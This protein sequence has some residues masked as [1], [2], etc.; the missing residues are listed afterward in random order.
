MQKNE[1]NGKKTR[2]ASKKGK[3]KTVE[4]AFG[5]AFDGNG[6]VVPEAAKENQ[7]LKVKVQN[8]GTAARDW[9]YRTAGEHE[10]FH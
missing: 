4:S 2:V 8:C 3:V 6:E 7:K 10:P 9:F 1:R 5:G